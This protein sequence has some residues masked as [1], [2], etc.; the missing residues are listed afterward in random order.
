MSIALRAGWLY[1]SIVSDE[2]QSPIPYDYW[3]AG[4]W[5]LFGWDPSTHPLHVIGSGDISDACIFS[6]HL[7]LKYLS[8]ALLKA[9]TNTNSGCI[10]NLG[11]QPELVMAFRRAG[12]RGF[13]MRSHAWLKVRFIG[14]SGN[15]D[16]KVLMFD[17]I[18]FR[19]VDGIMS[20]CSRNETGSLLRLIG[21]IIGGL[22]TE[23]I[24]LSRCVGSSE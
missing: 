3:C 8:P 1:R 18:P 17:F 14:S 2:R 19:S 6:W 12:G 16:V 21:C 10:P 15:E 5:D 4:L 9:I 7:I 13:K 22:M 23:R 24:D 11:I 20:T